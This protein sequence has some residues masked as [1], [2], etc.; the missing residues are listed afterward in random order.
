M[1]GDPFT[2][3]ITHVKRIILGSM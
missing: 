3:I 2:H 1:K